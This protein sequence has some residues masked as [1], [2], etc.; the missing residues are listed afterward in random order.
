MSACQIAG[1]GSLP[2]PS[3]TSEAETRLPTNANSVLPTKPQPGKFVKG[4]YDL[5]DPTLGL[6]S[7]SSFQQKLTMTLKGSLQGKP[8]EEIQHIERE[9]AGGNESIRVNGDT[10]LTDPTYLFSAQLAGFHYSQDL[11]GASCRAEPVKVKKSIEVNPALRLPAA[12]GIQEVG[13]ESRNNMEAIH[14]S[15]NEKSLLE[16][17]VA[18]KKAKGEVWVAKDSGIVLKYELE[19]ELAS[20]DISA[21]RIW[22]YELNQVNQG[23]MLHLPESC[24]PILSDLPVMPGAVELVQMPGFQR[25]HANANRVEAVA[26]FYTNLPAL[27]WKALPGSSPETAD[28]TTEVTVLS[29]VQNYLDGGRVLVIQLSGIK[30]ALQVTAQT[31]LTKAPVETNIS[32]DK[33]PTPE[34]GKA[35]PEQPLIGDRFF[36][37]DLPI[38]PGAVKI[39]V[40][41][42]FIVWNIKAPAAKVIAFYTQ[43]M[44]NSGWTLDQRVDNGKMVLLKWSREEETLLINFVDQGDMVRVTT[45]LPGGT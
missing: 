44:E 27:G 16:R 28:T 21:V 4:S 9:V 45:T 31:T 39:D 19:A 11:A 7:L 6:D 36:P 12:F 33:I 34:A 42:T 23:V 22:S 30:P 38:F 24:L 3:Q 25:Y 17:D 2:T 35:D 5:V 14:Y 8:Y 26:F 20:K 29:F 40:S 32:T 37:E 13:R 15:F 41:E 10:T 43:E 18:V 1:Q